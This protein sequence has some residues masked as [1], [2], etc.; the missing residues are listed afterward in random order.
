MNG[1]Y[2]IIK[3][4]IT[5][6]YPPIGNGNIV[7]LHTSLYGTHTKGSGHVG[8]GDFII[9]K[10]ILQLLTW[11]LEP[12]TPYRSRLVWFLILT[13]KMRHSDNHYVFSSGEFH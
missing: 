11:N 2:N 5:N 12:R 3:V 7:L 9:H 8:Y 4:I 10:A 13:L 1:S 6:G